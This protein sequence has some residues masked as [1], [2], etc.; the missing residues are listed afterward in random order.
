MPTRVE[1]FRD[2]TLAQVSRLGSFDYDFN[3]VLWHYT[4][5]VGLKAI[6]ESG[7]L[8]ATQ[9]SCL[10]DSSEIRY[11]IGMFKK[12][13]PT[14]SQSTKVSREPNDSLHGI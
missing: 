2:F 1:K 11:A 4:T 12:A 6:L 13:L 8:F 5:G 14:C 3:A 9:V 7:T 10:N